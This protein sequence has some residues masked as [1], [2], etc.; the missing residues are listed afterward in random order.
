M[1]DWWSCAR[2]LTA[3]CLSCFVFHHFCFVTWQFQCMNWL[4]Q[5]SMTF[6]AMS[7]NHGPCQPESRNNNLGTVGSRVNDWFWSELHLNATCDIL[8]TI[9]IQQTIEDLSCISACTLDPQWQCLSFIE[10]LNE[11][12]FKIKISFDATFLCTLL[13]PKLLSHDSHTALSSAQNTSIPNPSWW[14]FGSSSNNI[15]PQHSIAIM[16]ECQPL[17]VCLCCTTLW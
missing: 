8:Q 14:M 13:L 3:N 7:D 6:D 5:S 4:I 10:S 15:I 12:C 2:F 16:Q 1:K 9:L 17:D 11:H